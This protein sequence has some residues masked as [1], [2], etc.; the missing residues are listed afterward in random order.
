MRMGRAQKEEVPVKNGTTNQRSNPSY[1]GGK[2]F[3]RPPSQPMKKSQCRN[4]KI[5][6]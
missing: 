2:K 4:E 6:V 3:R 1:S 5:S